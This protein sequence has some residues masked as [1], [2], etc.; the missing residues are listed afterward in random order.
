M[1]LVTGTMLQSGNCRYFVYSEAENQH[2]RQQGRLLPP[3]HVKCGLAERHI[4]PL[5]RVKFHL[6]QLTGVATRPQSRKLPLFGDDSPGPPG[7][8]SIDVRAFLRPTYPA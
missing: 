8:I 4:G 7:P 5:G 1:F 6:S 2:L 3:I